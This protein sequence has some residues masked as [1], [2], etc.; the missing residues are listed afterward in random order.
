[1]ANS[2]ITSVA[3]KLKITCFRG[4][5]FKLVIN[6][7]DSSGSD[8]DFTVDSSDATIVDSVKIVITKSDGTY[9]V[10]AY[11]TV[12]EEPETTDSYT[13]SAGFVSFNDNSVTE[14]GK[15]TLE[16]NDYIRLWEGNYKYYVAT[17]KSTDEFNQTYWLYGDFV[18]KSISPNPDY[19]IN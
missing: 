6:V 9:P 5:K 12:T 19:Y 2:V 13:A 3:Q 4:E 18:V 10:N 14:D 16:T 8:Y 7:K 11:S 17:Q 15:I 1:M